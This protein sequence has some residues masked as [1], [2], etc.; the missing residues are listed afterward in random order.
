MESRF[1]SFHL[2]GRSA[3]DSGIFE[4]AEAVVEDGVIV[5]DGM[6]EFDD[7]IECGQGD[8]QRW[9]GADDGDDVVH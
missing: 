9:E 8:D 2:L 4:A 5:G 1:N 7:V 3:A 6:M